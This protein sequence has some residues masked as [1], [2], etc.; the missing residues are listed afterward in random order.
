MLVNIENLYHKQIRN[1]F[2]TI[3]F[4]I[5]LNLYQKIKQNNYLI[6]SETGYFYDSDNKL[7]GEITKR[8]R[9]FD[10]H[11]DDDDYE[12]IS[13]KHLNIDYVYNLY[14][15]QKKRHQKF[16]DKRTELM[17]NLLGID[18][19]YPEKKNLKIFKIIKIDKNVE[20]TSFDIMWD[21]S[22]YDSNKLSLSWTFG[23]E[24]NNPASYQGNYIIDN[25]LCDKFYF[26]NRFSHE[27]YFR[28]KKLEN[29]L[30]FLI[31]N[32]ITKTKSF[33]DIKNNKSVLNN[34]R[35]KYPINKENFAI[36]EIVFD[37]NIRSYNFD[38]ICF[39]D[40]KFLEIK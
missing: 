4:N 19:S 28:I 3:G 1:T 26:E 5:D 29:L 9:F 6:D 15:K 12:S 32:E 36:F 37:Q 38:F 14:L 17:F 33:Q 23:S 40:E 2:G 31:I 25:D 20:F 18:N 13:Y 34:L 11:D 22:Y 39:N 35:I 27:L 24:R 30:F 10:H 7:Q 16:S 21:H 8:I